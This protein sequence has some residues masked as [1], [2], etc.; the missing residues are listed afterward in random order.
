MFLC[1]IRVHD[2]ED[3][4]ADVDGKDYDDD[5][6]EGEDVEAN[7]VYVAD[8][9]GDEDENDFRIE[10]VPMSVSMTTVL[11]FLESTLQ[12][13]MLLSWSRDCPWHS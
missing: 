8:D 9:D 4:D 3:D 10:E 12:L 7:N 5:D 13:L 2:D 11:R 6:S 1:R